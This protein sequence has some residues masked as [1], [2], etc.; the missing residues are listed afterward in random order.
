MNQLSRKN[1]HLAHV[2]APH[3]TRKAFI[4]AYGEQYLNIWEKMNHQVNPKE[5]YPW[6]FP[7][8]YITPHYG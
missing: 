8:G 5:L 6:R 7:D 1:Q 3:M 2:A 4:R